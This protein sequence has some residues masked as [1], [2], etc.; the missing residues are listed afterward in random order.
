[1]ITNNK[2]KHAIGYLIHSSYVYIL[3]PYLVN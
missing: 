1:M 2:L 3:N